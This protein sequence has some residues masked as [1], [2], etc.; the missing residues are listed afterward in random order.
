MQ[1]AFR[2][3]V[4]V[5]AARPEDA[6]ALRA[7]L[8]ATYESTWRPQLTAAR[9]AQFRASGRTAQYVRSRGHLFRVAECEGVVAGFVDWV[10]DFIDAL[11]V[12]PAW[13][14]RGVGRALLAH[15][16]AA[17]RAAGHERVRLET[18]SFNTQALGFYTACGYATLA[19]YPDEEWDCGLTTVLMGKP[20][21]QP[22]AA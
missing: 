5:R 13:Q 19:T 11:H 16:E 20:L 10:D 7:V 2:P 3:P 8:W 4:T 15:A 21:V 22:G 6:P 9:D 1:Q 14:G 17:L 12:L 18:D